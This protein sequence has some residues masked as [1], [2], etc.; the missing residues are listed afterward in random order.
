MDTQTIQVV[1]TTTTTKPR[2]QV[3]RI[4]GFSLDILDELA[5]T[6][7]STTKELCGELGRYPSYVRRYLGNLQKYG[8]VEKRDWWGWEI[9]AFGDFVLSS[10]SSSS[11]NGERRVKE[12]RKKSERRVKEVETTPVKTRQLNISLWSEREDISG[13][14]LTVVVALTNHFEKTGRPYL[15]VKSFY[16]FRDLLELS[17]S[18]DSSDIQDIVV[19]LE[20]KGV[21]YQYRPSGGKYLK[22]GLTKETI[23]KM[24]H[25]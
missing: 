11:S 19:F 9:S 13:N 21:F 8:C 3:N 6:G 10:S 12:E 2:V 5:R 4:R 23:E 24:K 15:K 16:E 25:C 1:P 7:G 14:E 22:I 17:A 18:L 20:N